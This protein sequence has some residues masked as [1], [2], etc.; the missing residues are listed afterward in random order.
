MS[1][2]LVRKALDMLR[3]MAEEETDEDDEEEYDD[4]EYDDEEYDDEEVEENFDDEEEGEEAGESK[5]TKFWETFGKN[6]KLG[7]IEDAAN[8]AK[9]AKLLRF[10]TTQSK[11]QYTSLDEYLARM[12]RSQEA[13]YYLPGDSVESILKSPL[14]K[15]YDSH[16][17]EVLLL[18][19]PIDE[20]T[21]QHLAEYKN[22]KLKSIAKED[23]NAFLSDADQKK[24]MNRLKDM[25]KPLTDWWKKHLGKKV[26]KVAVS[27]RLVDE[28]AYVFTSQ[29]GYSA[30]MEKI[31]RAQAFAQSE[32]AADY[33]LAKKHFEINPHHP[34]MRELLERIT[35][36]AGDPDEHTV[37][38][39]NLLFNMALLNSGFVIEDPTEI[40][41]TMQQI[42]RSE[43]GLE[44]T[45]DFEEIEVDLDED[46]EEID[47]D[48][49]DEEEIE[50][51][52]DDN[53][54]D[55]IQYDDLDGD[56]SDL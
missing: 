49:P 26:E 38:T 43:L 37:E 24:K 52:L 54:G 23:G 46:V 12:P 11:D 4:E 21:M 44:R 53:V 3:M 7:V 16:G 36:A 6:I 39:M 35:T 10:Y 47:D 56:I 18:N 29:Y 8:R 1:K 14:I 13:I 22:K 51:N 25:Y 34:I 30:H 42:I 50:Y 55:N 28:P 20:F 19:D 33:M 45:G 17:I 5:Y 31:N 27:S 2:K 15:K 32:K 9:L 48:I 40:S 41:A